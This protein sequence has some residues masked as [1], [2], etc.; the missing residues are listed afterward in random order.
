MTEE[1]SNDE[2]PRFTI[3]TDGVAVPCDKE[4]FIKVVGELGEQGMI[5]YLNPSQIATFQARIRQHLANTD[6]TSHVD[7]MAAPPASPSK[8]TRD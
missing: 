6:P 2:T 5:P 3:L 8:K 7:R 1:K 4:E